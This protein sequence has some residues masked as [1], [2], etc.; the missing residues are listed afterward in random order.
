MFSAVFLC[1]FR[2]F[3]GPCPSFPWSF[4]KYQ[5][6][7]QKHQGFLS[8]GEPL[9]TLENR[10]KTPQKTKEFRSKKNTKETKTPRKRRTGGLR[11]VKK[12]LGVLGGF[13]C[14]FYLN[15]KEWKIRVR[16]WVAKDLGCNPDCPVQTP[17]RASSPKRGKKWPKKWILAPPEKKGEKL[18]IFDPISHFSA[19]FPLFP[20]GPKIHFSAPFFFSHFGPEARFGVCTG[21]SGS[22]PLSRFCF[23]LV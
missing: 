19:I 10:Q 8:L 20:G 22:R 4:R 5:R 7:P 18:A 23:A 6:K 12:I 17:N 16:T 1:F 3:T 2:V 13:P 15:T 9:K 21:Q 11:G 14:C